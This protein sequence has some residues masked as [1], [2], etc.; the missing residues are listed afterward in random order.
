MDPKHFDNLSRYLSDASSRRSIFT[1]IAGAA[2]AAVAFQMPGMAGARNKK[3]TSKKLALNT[4]GCVD[5]GK[6]CRGKDAN[7]CSGICEGK[8]P[9]NGKKD[10]SRCVDHNV[11]GCQVEQDQ[12]AGAPAQCGSST[13][14]LCYRTTGNASYCGDLGSCFECKTDADCEAAGLLEGAACVIC[15]EC[16][17]TGGT[18]CFAAAP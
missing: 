5:V 2:V 14:G 1:R 3:K 15:S 4:F 12:C 8:K 7:C 10:K 18:A 6:A 16:A 17:Q 13:M 9:K 11:L